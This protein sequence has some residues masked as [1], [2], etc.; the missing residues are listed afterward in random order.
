MIEKARRHLETVQESY[1]CHLLFA[2][3][4][5]GRMIG[6]GIAAILHGLFP[7]VFQHTGSMTLFALY[8]EIKERQKSHDKM[9]AGDA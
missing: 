5:G 9:P 2:L 7:A 3:S 6:G 8:D 4:F 1:L